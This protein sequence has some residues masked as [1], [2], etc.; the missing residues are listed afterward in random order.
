MKKAPHYLRVYVVDD[1]VVARRQFTELFKSEYPNC[2]VR[3]FDHLAKA[4]TGLY[5]PDVLLIDVSCVAPL[6]MSDTA[7]AYGPIAWYGKQYPACR[8]L[9]QSAA[10]RNCVSTIV[11]E[12]NEAIGEKQ[13]VYAGWGDWDSI[14]R[15][16]ARVISDKGITQ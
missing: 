10:G 16:V 4:M 11:D 12:V 1:D 8:I 5:S 14:K 7:H 2:E 6:M 3:T 9:I 15:E 13:A